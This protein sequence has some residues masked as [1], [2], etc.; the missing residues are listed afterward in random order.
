MAAF[1][2]KLEADPWSSVDAKDPQKK[3]VTGPVTV[4]R[5]RVGGWAEALG[6]VHSRRTL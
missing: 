6:V 1:A 2:K 4:H 3:D 5:R